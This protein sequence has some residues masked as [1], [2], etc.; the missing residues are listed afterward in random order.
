MNSLNPSG[1]AVKAFS[2]KGITVRQHNSIPAA[3]IGAQTPAEQNEQAQQIARITDPVV[4]PAV[5]Q[6]RI[7]R[8]GPNIGA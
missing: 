8:Y 6:D 3:Q 2:R 7:A 1:N 4:G 5:P